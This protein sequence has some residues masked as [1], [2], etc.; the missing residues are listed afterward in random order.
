[1]MKV[2]FG[3][4]TTLGA[5]AFLIPMVWMGILSPLCLPLPAMAGLIAGFLGGGLMDD[6]TCEV[7]DARDVLIVR[8]V[9]GREA[10]IP[11]RDIRRVTYLYPWRSSYGLGKFAR[12][13]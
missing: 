5:Y 9:D 6:F 3:L 4:V 2:L 13:S 10:A 11:L 7:W 1:M 12:W 8:D